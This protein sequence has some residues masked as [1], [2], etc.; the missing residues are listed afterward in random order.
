MKVF[1]SLLRVFARP[2]DPSGQMRR[3]HQGPELQE[4][5][6]PPLIDIQCY[7]IKTLRRS[8]LGLNDP[9]DLLTLLGSAPATRPFAVRADSIEKFGSSEVTSTA[10]M[11][12]R[13]SHSS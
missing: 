4:V 13:S 3:I 1:A 12:S 11:G 2:Q 8:Y 9:D 6:S 5:L 10:L 7:G